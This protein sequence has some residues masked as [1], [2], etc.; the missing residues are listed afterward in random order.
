MR[1]R[2]DAAAVLA[3]ATRLKQVVTN[4]LSNAVKYNVPDG[5]VT[6]SARRLARA[7]GDQIEIT[8]ADTGLGLTPE[9]QAGLF[10][11]YNRLGREK[12][13]IEGTGIGLVISRRLSELMGGTLVA[14]SISGVGSSFTLSL[15]AGE[16]AK[17]PAAPCTHAAPAP[18]AQR[19]VHNVEDNETNI[20][21]MRGVLAQRSQIRLETS[22][23]GLDGLDG[24]EA[25]RRT[26]PDLV[27]LDMHLP[28]IN[29][30]ALL[31][32]LKQDDDV[33]D[34]P[35]VVV[36]ADA[37]TLAIQ[38]ALTSGAAH[39]V[40]KPVDVPQLLRLVDEILEGAS[41]ISRTRAAPP[42]GSRAGPSAVLAV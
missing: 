14:T 25:I 32:H 41:P 30:L 31:R 34:I 10:Q 39:Y 3:D 28:D 2:G 20:E 17:A 24:L 21:I 13:D 29:G 37:T 23:L 22:M 7:G 27:L 5:R 35:V 36:S 1:Q 26:R 11:P 16:A 6:L 42:P 38:Q 19:L 12:T 33:A 9:Q 40:T 18:Y 4:L 15:P 8:V